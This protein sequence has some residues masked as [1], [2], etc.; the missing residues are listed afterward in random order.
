MLF[1]SLHPDIFNIFARE[2]KH[3]YAYV[4]KRYYQ[5]IVQDEANTSLGAK[6]VIRLIG[7]Y[8]QDFLQSKPD[9]MFD[10]EDRDPSRL[11]ARLR[12][13][14]WFEEI[15]KGHGYQAYMPF[16][17]ATM[18][19]CLLQIE[20]DQIG[21]GFGDTVANVYS[22]LEMALKSD[23]PGIKSANLK[24]ALR[25]AQGFTGHLGRIV[26][27]ISSIRQE[28]MRS[29]TLRDR[30]DG[31][32]DVFV[33]KII[34]DD[35]VSITSQNNPFRLHPYIGDI[36]DKI[37]QVPEI[38][39]AF[40]DDMIGQKPNMSAQEARVD[41]LRKTAQIRKSL[42]RILSIREKIDGERM[43]TERGFRNALIYSDL[44]SD[45]GA[46]HWEAGMH[47]IRTIAQAQIDR[48]G[49]ESL[50]EAQIE[51][52]LNWPERELPVSAIDLAKP[53][54]VSPH[55]KPK[56]TKRQEDDPRVVRYDAIVTAFEMSCALTPVTVNALITGAL[57]S[58]QKVSARDIDVTQA[59]DLVLFSM[60]PTANLK[61]L[62]LDGLYEVGMLDGRFESD[63]ID[64]P[65]FEIRRR[66]M[67]HEFL[68]TGAVEG[69]SGD[70]Q[71]AQAI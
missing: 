69:S 14:G 60:L 23:E 44:V 43:M 39:D 7:E 56:A 62:G 31:F 9:E 52:V 36:L 28:L 42:E 67:E 15:Q 5:E 66:Q 34:L 22:Y 16:A 4:L 47:D 33:K 64:A 25:R 59:S 27:S 61:D 30:V 71:N 24:G 55:R 29:R 11:Y 32:F 21:E 49:V 6:E 37:E 12:S 57:G 40:I 51:T 1:G 19:E 18:L 53:Q 26:T 20:D 54:L 45:E 65:N 10:A 8:Q 41:V 17:P 3:L 38:Q 48:G 50:D 63:L 46:G 70:R 58:S 13:C 2:D 35:Y 68:D